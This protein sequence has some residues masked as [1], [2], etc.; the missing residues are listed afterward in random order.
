MDMD[1]MTRR[2]VEKLLNDIKAAKVCG[3]KGYSPATYFYA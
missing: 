2:D 3:G 1:E